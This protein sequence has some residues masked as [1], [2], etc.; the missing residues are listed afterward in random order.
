MGADREMRS[1]REE[2]EGVEREMDSL[3]TAGTTT[4]TIL[5]LLSP[6]LSV[7]HHQEEK[8]FYFFFPSVHGFIRDM[9]SE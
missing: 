2:E 4:P 8:D 6:H 1:E 5:A 9:N 7:Y 3:A